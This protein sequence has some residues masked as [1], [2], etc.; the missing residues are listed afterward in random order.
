MTGTDKHGD[1][2]GRS[3]MG[4]PDKTDKIE[5]GRFESKVMKKINSQVKTRIRILM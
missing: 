4:L 2:P 3:R 1:L 5:L